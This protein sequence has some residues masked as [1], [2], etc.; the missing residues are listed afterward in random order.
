MQL[1]CAPLGTIARRLAFVSLGTVRPA[2]K[3]EL[4]LGASRSSSVR[5]EHA[6]EI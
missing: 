5:V 2:L 4:V 3:R 6:D 1:E